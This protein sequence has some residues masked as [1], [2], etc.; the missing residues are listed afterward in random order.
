VSP[1]PGARCL[2][3]AVEKL[4]MPREVFSMVYHHFLC[5][6][7]KDSAAGDAGLLAGV[8]VADAAADRELCARAMEHIYHCHAGAI[9]AL[10]GALSV[11]T[12]FWLQLLQ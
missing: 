10:S 1:P 12:P 7:D 2:Q 8:V 6:A 5:L 9:G 4:L 3:G 11:S